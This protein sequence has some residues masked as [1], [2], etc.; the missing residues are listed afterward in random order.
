MRGDSNRLNE[1]A[2]ELSRVEGRCTPKVLWLASYGL[3][4]G[5]ALVGRRLGLCDISRVGCVR[6]TP[7]V[8]VAEMNEE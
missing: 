5:D 8:S 7:T 3:G 4:L 1:Y 2:T 6:R